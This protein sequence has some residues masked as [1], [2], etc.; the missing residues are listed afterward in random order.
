MDFFNEIMKFSVFPASAKNKA[1]RLNTIEIFA[2]DVV[3]Y[4]I[5]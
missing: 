4:I 3:Y 5:D 2:D 1:I